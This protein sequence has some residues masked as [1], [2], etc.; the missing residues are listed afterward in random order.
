MSS[1]EDVDTDGCSR[2]F[3]AVIDELRESRL[4]RESTPK[5]M[6]RL[7]A[8]SAALLCAASVKLSASYGD[9]PTEYLQRAAADA[10]EVLDNRFREWRNRRN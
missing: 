7:G 8:V 6:K 3:R 5:D 9:I 1:L 10:A 4:I 2:W